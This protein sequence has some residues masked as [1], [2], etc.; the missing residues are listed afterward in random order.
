MQQDLPTTE[1]MNLQIIPTF[2]KEVSLI[3]RE[4]GILVILWLHL[5]WSH[6]KKKNFLYSS[7]VTFEVFYGKEHKSAK[8]KSQFS[9]AGEFLRDTLKPYCLSLA[10][11][12]WIREC[13]TTSREISGCPLRVPCL[14]HPHS[15]WY[16]ILSVNE[17]G[18]KRL[19][20]K[21]EK[22]HFLYIAGFFY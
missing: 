15:S 7:S 11:L 21:R 5:L 13:K 6:L 1:N 2:W 14:W 17:S 3:C 18:Q 4:I 10:R 22:R 12:Y 8:F 20:K 9:E 16:S 19:S